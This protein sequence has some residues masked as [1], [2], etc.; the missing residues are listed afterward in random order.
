MSDDLSS[1]L[2]S[3][4]IDR[5]ANARPPRRLG[6]VAPT[7]A[8]IL[9]ALA[10]Y[11]VGLPYLEAKVFKTEVALTEVAS[12]SPAQASVILT[13]SGYVVAQRTTSVAP[14]VAGRV[15]EVAV[16]QGQDVRAGDLLFRLDPADQDAAIA[17][18]RSQAAAAAARVVTAKA[19]VAQAKANL[20]EA[21]QTAERERALARAGVSAKG[22]AA[23]LEARVQSVKE[24][25]ASAEAQVRAAQAEVAAARAQV[26]AL[27]VGSDNL[28]LTAPIS[29]RVLNKPPEV[30]EFVGPQPAGV[31]VDMGGVEIA[32]FSTLTVE[33]DVP[34]SRLHQLKMGGPAE[35]VLDAYP[36][37]RLRGEAYE[38]TPRVNRAKAT[39]TV[40]VRFLDPAENALPD[41]AARVSFLSSALDAEQMKQKPKTIVPSAA[42]TER[43]GAKVV[44]VAEGGRVRMVPVE[45]GP[46]FAGGFELEAG[47]SP[48]TKLVS[49]PPAT[50]TDGQRI[51]EENAG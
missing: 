37:Q 23:D 29:G 17:T 14:K 9:L 42:V 20:A 1:D 41:M 16:R 27:E 10:G 8:V 50:L 22:Q 18:A 35:I 15:A 4:K 21:A 38:V 12:V 19:G 43:G 34:E 31:A 44:F 13:S 7:V 48:G 40:K 5:G 39:V 28:V 30:G 36:D 32:D 26:K 3:L 2:A 25:V 33:T 51:K 49:E 47:P 46:P 6:W 11:F 45:L 24:S